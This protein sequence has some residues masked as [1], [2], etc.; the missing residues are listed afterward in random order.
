MKFFLQIKKYLNLFWVAIFIVSSLGVLIF[1]ALDYMEKNAEKAIYLS[2]KEIR[3][4][5]NT[6]LEA[7]AQA[8]VGEIE[9]LFQ[10]GFEAPQLLSS[11]FLSAR[12]WGSPM[13]RND[14]SELVRA[15]LDTYTDVSSL[16]IHFEPNAFD[17]M[18][19]FFLSHPGDSPTTSNQGT[20]E[21]YWVRENHGLVFYET[22]DTSIKYDS[23]I[24]Q[25]GL[26]KAEWYLCPM[27]TKSL[28]L[29][30]PY[31]WENVKDSPILMMSL[32][33]PLLYKGEFLGIAGA[34]IN[35]ELVQEKL[36]RLSND[37][38]EGNAEI[39]LLSDDM[40]II[41]SNVHLDYLGQSLD[42]ID[43]DLYNELIG[44]SASSNDYIFLSKSFNVAK[45]DIL[46]VIRIPT[47]FV[48]SNVIQLKETLLDNHINT[49]I[50]IIFVACL[51]I[52]L[53]LFIGLAF[54]KSR[55]RL[56]IQLQDA[57]LVLKKTQSDLIQSEKLASLGGLVAGIAHE[58]NTPIGNAVLASSTLQS[59]IKVFGHHLESGLKRSTL[60]RFIFDTN[61]SSTII[62]RN[63]EKAS[64]LISSFKQVAV[65]QT[66]LNKRRF[67]LTEILD[68]VIL[69]LNPTIKH[70]VHTVR[71][72]VIDSIEMNSYPGALGQVLINLIQNCLLHAFDDLPGVIE[73]T[74]KN[75]KLNQGYVDIIVSDNGKGI[76][77]E[78]MK[79]I[80]EPFF[81][82]KMGSGGT[83]LGLSIVHNCVV[84]ILQ[85]DIDVKSKL[86]KGSSFRL[87]IPIEVSH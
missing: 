39:T 38:F 76:K 80:F 17:G 42:E 37:L 52:I 33:M 12:E 54:F 40:R 24:D 22:P 31:Y 73:V 2:E 58:L 69:M 61:E 46:F 14:G 75:S 3:S 18:D 70:S 78:H 51:I 29:S 72:K 9:M 79:R 57:L 81:T 41:S 68:E 35:A 66:T 77:E 16:Y 53:S 62:L 26:R 45:S 27:E 10:N 74:V 23:E 13:S 55:E 71:L 11:I 59:E 64:T 84:G 28:C 7:T 5:V 44:E 49:Q 87:S 25:F 82:T 20:F 86:N 63:L 15:V 4:Y 60:E 47:D 83:G 48:F 43:Y 21:V 85:G 19:E 56:T 67:A 34:D 50:K 30:N 1:I 6:Q 36:Q 8:F 65:D 32:T